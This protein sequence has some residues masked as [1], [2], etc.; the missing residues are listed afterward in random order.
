LIIFAHEG[1]QYF[2]FTFEEFQDHLI[3]FFEKIAQVTQ[4]LIFLIGRKLTQK[5]DD[6]IVLIQLTEVG[7]NIGKVLSLRI[8]IDFEVSSL[9]LTCP[10]ILFGELGRF[11]VVV[12]NMD[13]GLYKLSTC[14]FSR[15]W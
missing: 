14:I 8:V 4:Q 3:L 5:L 1:L 11:N 10:E 13:A 6:V 12:N 2:G 9:K 7:S 15:L